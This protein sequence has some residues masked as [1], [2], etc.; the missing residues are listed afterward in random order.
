MNP[1]KLKKRV[2][3]KRKQL[4]DNVAAKKKK[5]TRSAEKDIAKMWKIAFSL[6]IIVIIT[7]VF[8]AGIILLLTVPGK[9]E[10]KNKK[11]INSEKI[12]TLE[13]K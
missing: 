4:T 3:V 2:T 13:D 7:S 11:M 6:K 1:L 8:A 12:E 10:D 9:Q 5:L